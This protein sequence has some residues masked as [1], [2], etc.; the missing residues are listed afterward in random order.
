VRHAIRSLEE[1]QGRAEALL[2]NIL[3]RQIAD[4]LRREAGPIADHHGATTVLFADIVG[5]T[6][7]SAGVAPGRVVQL[8][9]EVFSRFDVLAEEHGMEKI[10]TIGDAYM[11]VAGLPSARIDHAAAA[12]RMALAM[13][14]SMQRLIGPDGAPLRLRLG[15]HSGPVVAGI[16]GK[17][18]FLYDLW[19]DTVNTASR[20]E[21][22]G[23]P[24]TIQLSD[25]TARLLPDSFELQER[26]W[27]ELKG[28]GQ[29]RA[30]F[31]IRE[32]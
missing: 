16:I 5:F 14:D 29:I 8:L 10:K 21:T 28:K 12:A 13:R 3:P 15:L 20:M 7:L 32:R 11:A 23:E 30:W 6:P 4:R 17:R 1:A 18:K 22:Q 19:G 26:G 9:D 24:D 2:L 31:L 25:A 27:V